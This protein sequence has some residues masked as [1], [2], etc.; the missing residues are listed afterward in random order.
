MEEYEDLKY[1]NELESILKRIPKKEISIY[2]EMITQINNSIVNYQC[3]LYV[4]EDGSDG[5]SK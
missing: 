5:K 3:N 2:Q 4:T 1:T